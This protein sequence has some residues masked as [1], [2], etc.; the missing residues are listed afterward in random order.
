MQ[1]EDVTGIGFTTRRTTQQQRDLAVGPGLLGQIV[2]DDQRV[3][4]AVTEVFAHGTAG[5][6]G[7]VLHGG[8]FRSR[9]GHDDGVGEGAVLFQL[10][11]HVGNRALLLADGDIDAFDA[12]ALLIDDRVDGQCG[13]AGLAIADD[14]LTLTA[15]DRDHGVDRLVAGLHRLGDRL[16]P[17][18][19]G[20]NLLD[21]ARQLGAERALG[22]NR[23]A[24]RVDHS[25]EQFRS[26]RH[27]QNA[28][29]GLDRIA[30][31]QVLVVTEH[32]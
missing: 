6:S 21:G 13:F 9:G 4:A 26:D 16:A 14:Q 3:F 2:V 1:I 28:A 25:A 32:H 31:A 15:T 20:R 8:R 23:I 17:D 11:H 18:H 19:A 5:V 22:I 24:E 27:F 10:A 12:A 7:D 30:F 29:G